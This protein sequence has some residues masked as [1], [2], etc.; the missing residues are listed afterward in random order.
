MLTFETVNSAT[1]GMS[2]W[3][4]A[5][6]LAMERVGAP[7]LA[8]P[9]RDHLHETALDLAGEV[10]VRLDAVDRDDQGRR[11]RRRCGPRRPG[12]PAGPRPARPSPCSIGSRSRSTRASC[13]RRRGPRA[14]PPRWRRRGCPWPA[15]RR[16]PRRR[17]GPTRRPPE[18]PRRSCRCRGCPRPGRPASRARLR[19]RPARAPR[20]RPRPRRSPRPIHAVPD[21]GP[22]RQIAAMNS[23]NGSRRAVRAGDSSSQVA[24]VGGRPI[25][26]TPTAR[27]LRPQ[28]V[29]SGP[30]G[31]V[32]A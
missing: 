28:T 31:A 20:R 11:L 29:S 18:R 26:S 30:R 9:D 23:A 25:K 2:S 12:R 19:P 16:P 27:Q 8:E 1:S 21:Q 22:A 10:R 3:N 24:A 7:L 5:K 15:R 32:G 14:G 17:R 4:V 6:A 13:R